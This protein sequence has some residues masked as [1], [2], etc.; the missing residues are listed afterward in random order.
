MTLPLGTGM[1]DG[2]SRMDFRMALSMHGI[3]EIVG[4]S[5]LVRQTESASS[6]IR[7]RCSGSEDNK[8]RNK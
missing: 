2:L 4:A 5:T 1:V 7:A 3:E 8:S 6:L